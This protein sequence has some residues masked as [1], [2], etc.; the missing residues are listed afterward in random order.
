MQS[1]YHSKLEVVINT[2]TGFIGSLI[3]TWLCVHF[4]DNRSLASIAAVTACTTW[5]LI[6][7]Y[8]IRRKFAKF[9]YK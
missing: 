4:I 6:R 9:E 7:G 5:S 1:K 2:S 8:W 3:I